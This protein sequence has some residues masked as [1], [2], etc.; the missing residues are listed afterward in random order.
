MTILYTGILLIIVSIIRQKKM[1]LY[2]GFAF[3]FAIMAFQEGVEGDYMG[4]KYKFFL[5]ENNIS[6][7][8]PI[9]D[10]LNQLFFPLGWRT[11]IVL[12]SLFQIWIMT[13]ITKKYS[14]KDFSWTSPIIFFFWFG[15]M[16]IQMKALRQALAI[17]MC[18]LPFT[19][20][21]INKKMKWP[22]CFV[23]LLIAFYIHNSSLIFLPVIALY[24][25]HLSYGWLNK[26]ENTKAEFY[27][28]ILMTISFFVIYLSK[29]TILKDYF[30]QINI[31]YSD[32]RLAGY[33]TLE[34]IG[35]S[36]EDVSLLIIIADAIFVFINTWTFQYSKGIT[37][38]FIIIT[39]CASFLDMLLFGLG[40]LPRIGYYYLPAM[41]VTLPNSTK[42]LQQRYGNIMAYGFIVFFLAYAIKTSLPFLTEDNS[43]T[44][45]SYRFFFI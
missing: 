14:D 4:Y 11:F 28:P 35:G 31:L 2:I 8:E 17:N 16:L 39:V 37:S 38:I 36:I 22:W 44:F 23:P 13:N 19:L 10:I 3:V 12:I 25:M 43:G 7:E 5:Q 45:T 20:N 21:I 33:T 42:M 30:T 18:F 1:S 29:E 32:F 6:K 9:W 41:L 26:K 40:T 24:Y 27:Y 34:E 15:M